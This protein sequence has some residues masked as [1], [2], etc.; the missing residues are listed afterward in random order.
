MSNYTITEDSSN[1]LLLRFWRE[2]EERKK[3]EG[4]SSQD[5]VK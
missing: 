1:Q 5:G 4:V 2:K 3:H